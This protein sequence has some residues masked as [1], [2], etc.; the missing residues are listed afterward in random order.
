M[1]DIF[2]ANRV[3]MGGSSAAAWKFAEPGTTHTGTIAEPP[4]ARQEREYVKDDPGG[5]KPKTF[6]SGD[7]IMGILVELQ[8]EE[9]D[10]ASPDDD[11]RRTFYC[12][13]R[14]LRDS[15]RGAVRAAGADGLAVGGVLTV[16]FT[17]REDPADKRSRKHWDVTYVPPGNAALMGTPAAPSPA[18]TSSPAAAPAAPAP[19]AAPAGI[20]PEQAAQF[21]AWQAA[22]KG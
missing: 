8:T 6:P 11:G 4:T 18:A 2:D 10:A 13:G 5:G 21:A 17:R 1:T 12:E 9:R 14:Y 20:T 3:L 7:P 19:V 22:Q 16:T 15:V